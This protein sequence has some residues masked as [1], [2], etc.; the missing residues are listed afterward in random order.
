[1]SSYVDVPDFSPIFTATGRIHPIF[2]F[3]SI[4]VRKCKSQSC[5]TI[6][7]VS[8]PSLLSSSTARS[9]LLPFLFLL[10]FSLAS[11]LAWTIRSESIAASAF[12][13]RSL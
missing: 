7:L 2:A 3:Y 4:F 10:F 9:Q 12:Y 1:M 5:V 8:F 11:P 6:A 13:V